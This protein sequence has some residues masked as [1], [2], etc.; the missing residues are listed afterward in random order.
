MPHEVTDS[1]IETLRK[2]SRRKDG[3]MPFPRRQVTIELKGNRQRQCQL[4]TI[5]GVDAK[6]EMVYFRGSGRSLPFNQ[7]VSVTIEPRP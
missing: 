7:I 4:G 3:A 6:K 5:D 1:G 2:E